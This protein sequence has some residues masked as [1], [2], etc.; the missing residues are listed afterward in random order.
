MEYQSPL[1]S[2]NLGGQG[3]AL[4][5]KLSTCFFCSSSKPELALLVPGDGIVA[6][7]HECSNKIVECI[8]FRCKKCG[9]TKAVAEKEETL[10]QRLLRKPL[11]EEEIKRHV[12]AMAWIPIIV[13]TESCWN[14]YISAS[15]N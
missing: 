1:F 11:S 4:L 9:H 5:E 15:N 13:E 8:L 10:R 14:C 12:K 3:D 7:C 2:K 6:I